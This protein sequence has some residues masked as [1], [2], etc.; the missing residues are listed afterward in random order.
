MPSM[1][2]E[3]KYDYTNYLSV[4]I[5]DQSNGRNRVTHRTVYFCIML[6]LVPRFEWQWFDVRFALELGL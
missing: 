1:S 4:H 3:R 6:Y 2:A 5:N